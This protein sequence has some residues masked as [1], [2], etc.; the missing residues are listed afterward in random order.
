MQ[1]GDAVCSILVGE[2]LAET[3]VKKRDSK[4]GT[5]NSGNEFI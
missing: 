1:D 2:L 4:V 3:L 5:K